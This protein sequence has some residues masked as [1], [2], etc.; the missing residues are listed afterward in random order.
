MQNKRTFLIFISLLLIF[1]SI[2]FGATAV[3]KTTQKITPIRILIVPGHDNDVWGTQYNTLKEGDMTRVLASNIYTL[4]S[5]D[6]RFKVFITRNS[7]GYTKTF[8]DYFTEK[9][10]AIGLFKSDAKKKTAEKVKSGDFTV[11][12]GVPHIS[13]SEDTAIKL[14]GINKWVNENKIDAVVHIHFDDEGRMS[15]GDIGSYKGFSVYYPDGELLNS[16]PSKKLAQNIFNKL[17]TKYQISTY[18]KESSGL[19]PDQ[20]LI[21]LGSNQTLNKDTKSVLIEYGYIYEK[22]FRKSTTRH[23]AY[24][25]M[26][27]LTV[28]GIKNYFYPVK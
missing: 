21:A 8:S 23:Q 7:L 1:P 20:K 14:Y 13:V 24:K 28:K 10:E 4:L 18:E 19:V 16:I 22:M 26:A 27:D 15:Y 11:E 3:K 25:T 12:K 9:R 2:S 17:K 5:K 6:K